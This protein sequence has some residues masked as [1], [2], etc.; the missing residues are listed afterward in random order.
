[1]KSK[2]QTFKVYSDNQSVVLLEDEDHVVWMSKTSQGDKFDL[3]RG[4]KAAWVRRLFGWE[5][6]QTKQYITQ[7]LTNPIG[8]VVSAS[9]K[10]LDIEAKSYAEIPHWLAVDFISQIPSTNAQLV[11]IPA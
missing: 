5:H 3:L 6:P 10:I 11:F 8:T 4:V 9:V 7:V 2:L 1:M